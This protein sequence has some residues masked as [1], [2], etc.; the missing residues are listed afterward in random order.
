MPKCR[1]ASHIRVSALVLLCCILWVRCN[2]VGDSPR[3]GN[4]LPRVGEVVRGLMWPAL[5]PWVW[6]RPAAESICLPLD[7][8]RRPPYAY[9]RGLVVALNDF[10]HLLGFGLHSKVE[11]DLL[12]RGSPYF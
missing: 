6:L 1:D 8:C 7:S 3:S 11:I 4:P 10:V 5:P 9:H 12:E 2:L